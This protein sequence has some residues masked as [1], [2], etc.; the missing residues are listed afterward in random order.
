MTASGVMLSDVWTTGEGK[1]TR[2]PPCVWRFQG[3]R[4]EPEVG[5]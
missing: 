2:V 5:E 3:A 4:V 1:H